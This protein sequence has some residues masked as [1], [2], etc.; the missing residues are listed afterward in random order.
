VVAACGGSGD[1]TGGPGDGDAAATEAGDAAPGGDD[2]DGAYEGGD[3]EDTGDDGLD[4]S[5]E[6]GD[7]G[8]P[9]D[10]G[11]GGEEARFNLIASPDN[12]ECSYQPNGGAGGADQLTVFFY[13][14]IIGGNPPDVPRVSVTGS[15]DTG[16][17]T[18]FSAGPDNQAVQVAQF[19][20]RPDDFGRTHTLTLTVD[21][22]DDVPETDE[23]DNRIAV[24]VSLPS[25]RPTQAIDPLPCSASRA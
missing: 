3:T 8:D 2:A 13:F 7:A 10:P 5:G 25:P 18:S 16:L 23:S 21:A 19:A 12:V 4:T 1:P 20:L 24:S 11:V 15:S 17:S 9:A 14:L 6:T 22:S